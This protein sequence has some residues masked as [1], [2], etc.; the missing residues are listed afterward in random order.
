MYFQDFPLTISQGSV[1]FFLK[2]K[3]I[4]VNMLTDLITP[5]GMVVSSLITAQQQCPMLSINKSTSPLE[6]GLKK[7]KT[8][9]KFYNWRVT[10]NNVGVWISFPLLKKEKEKRKKKRKK[11]ER[12]YSRFLGISTMYFFPQT[13]ASKRY[14]ERIIGVNTQGRKKEKK[15]GQGEKERRNKY[16]SQNQRLGK[17]YLRAQ[18]CHFYSLLYVQEEGHNFCQNWANLKMIYLEKGMYKILRGGKGVLTEAK[19]WDSREEGNIQAG[20]STVTLLAE[21]LEELRP[22]EY[23]SL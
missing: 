4:H 15:R 10:E 7:T 18:E 5:L 21:V 14:K 16:P 1:F 6:R 3:N 23:S 12:Y 2:H 19:P 20:Q 17:V 22:C 9:Q 13:N 8:K 11:R